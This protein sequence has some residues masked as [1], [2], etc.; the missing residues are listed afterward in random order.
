LP[1]DINV[2][3]LAPV[4]TDSYWSGVFDSPLGP[5]YFEQGI[6]SSDERYMGAGKFGIYTNTGGPKEIVAAPLGAYEN[7]LGSPGAFAVVTRCPIISGES[8]SVTLY[9]ETKWIVMNDYQPREVNVEIDL[10]EGDLTLGSVSAWYDITVDGMV[11][12]AGSG[13]DPM[14][15]NTWDMEPIYPD[16]L[17]SNFDADLANAVYTRVITVASASILTVS[18]WEVSDCPDID[19][20]LWYDANLNGIADDST[21]WYVG[22]GGSSESLTLRDPADGQYLVKVLGYTVTGEPGYFGLNVLQGI[23]G[24]AISAVDLESE[25]GTGMHE[26]M[27]VYL[28]P[29]VPG[30]YVGAATFGFMGANDMFSI[31]VITT[32]VE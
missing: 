12:A 14:I 7:A 5:G 16:I 24:A 22:T 11:E 9:G 30:V 21:Y 31:P 20:A 2:H 32:V 28:V 4:A 10:S 3:V 23:Q 19:L 17:T 27:I 1:T 29:A 18:V 13:V 26:F 6:A 15:S 25:V 8:A